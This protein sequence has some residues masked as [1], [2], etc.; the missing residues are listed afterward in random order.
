MLVRFGARVWIARLAITWGLAAMALALAG[1]AVSFA[2]LRFLLGAAEAGFTPGVMFLFGLWFPAQF[3]A[4]TNALFLLGLPLGTALSAALS[5]S[6]LAL[7]GQFGLLGWQ[8]VFVLEG[9][10]PVLLGFAA[11]VILADGPANASWLSPGERDA[12]ARVLA[13]EPKTRKLAATIGAVLYD[14]DTWRLGF[15]CLGVNA[16]IAVLGLW[17]P[18]V[19]QAFGG[20]S[21]IGSGLLASAIVLPGA[22]AMLLW[23]C[24]SDVRG[25]RVAHFCLAATAACLGWVSRPH[26]RS[27]SSRCRY[28]PWLAREATP[29]SAYSGRSPSTACPTKLRRRV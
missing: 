25:D 14:P 12:L 19:V 13:A 11:L 26:F 20:T 21:A 24:R 18:Q 2:A 27:Q 16:S 5:S 4:R 29:H 6:L 10:P 17:L 8:W 28:W 1:G 15:V 7:N 23:S 9:L 3:R 22:L